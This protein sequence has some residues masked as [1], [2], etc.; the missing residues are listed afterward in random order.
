MGFVKEQA[1]KADEAVQGVAFG[2]GA[3]D[4]CEN[5]DDPIW[6]DVDVEDAKALA[7][8]RFASGEYKGVFASADEFADEVERFVNEN[9]T[10]ECYCASKLAED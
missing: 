10:D 7:R 4:R 8:E 6:G 5:C 1:M 3:L 9:G 2:S